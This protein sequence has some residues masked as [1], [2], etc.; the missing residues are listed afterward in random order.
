MT[1]S[2]EIYVNGSPYRNDYSTADFFSKAFFIHEMTH[3]WQYQNN[4]LFVKTSA[5]WGQ[6]CHLG[7][8]NEMYKYTLEDGKS[9]IDYGIEQQA[10]MV[11]DYYLVVKRGFN[12][13]REGRIQN[14]GTFAEKR[15]LLKKVMADFIADPLNP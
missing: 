6:I 2:G 13:F 15:E 8:Y 1:P 9:L 11:E 14:R 3:V 5:I 10:A 4:V 7:D 12:Q